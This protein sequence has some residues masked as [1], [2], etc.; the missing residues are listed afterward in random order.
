MKTMN[1]L[2]CKGIWSKS[3]TW[4]YSYQFRRKTFKN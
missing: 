3:N 2:L 1:H 4:K